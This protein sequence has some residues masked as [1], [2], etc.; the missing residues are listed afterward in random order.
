MDI[1]VEPKAEQLRY[2]SLVNNAKILDCI[3]E[4]HQTALKDL[5]NDCLPLSLHTDGS[6]DRMHK[7]DH[8][9]GTIMCIGTVKFG[10]N[11]IKV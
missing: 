9:A 8:A 1:L 2:L 10:A 7:D 11:T 4:A 3:V 5:F 6:F